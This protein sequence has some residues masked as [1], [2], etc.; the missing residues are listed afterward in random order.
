MINKYGMIK[1][2][3]LETY[4]NDNGVFSLEINQTNFGDLAYIYKH[5]ISDNGYKRKDVYKSK[6]F[7]DSRDNNE[8]F[9]TNIDNAKEW[10]YEIM[11]IK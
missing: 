2:M 11:E 3:E 7:D 8:L 6:Y 10:F 5:D 1:E 4:S 9:D